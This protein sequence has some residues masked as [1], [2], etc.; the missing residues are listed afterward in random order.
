ERLLRTRGG[1]TTDQM[2]LA[3][4]Q[5]AEIP[6]LNG[7][8]TAHAIARHYAALIGEVDG[9]RIVGPETLAAACEAQSDGPDRVLGAHTRCGLGFALPPSLGVPSGPR[10]FGHPGSG[11]SLGFADPAAGVAF[12][13]A[14]NQMGGVA[15][16]DVRTT[17][18]VEALYRCLAT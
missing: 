11:G 1:W 12:G 13:Y 15:P 6:S 14:P 2:N 16:G 18:L 17:S 4:A 5:E 8:G 3:A 9:A 7:I 10:S